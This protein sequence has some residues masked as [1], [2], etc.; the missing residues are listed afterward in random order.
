MQILKQQIKENIIDSSRDYFIKE[1]YEKATL[2]DI[3]DKADISVGN[4]YRYF[5]SK[6]EILLEIMNRFKDNMSKYDFAHNNPLVEASQKEYHEFI[7]V[8]TEIIVENY[9]DFRLTARNKQNEHVLEF[10]SFMMN[11]SVRTIKKAIPESRVDETI[12]RAWTV[13]T[14]EG[15]A[16]LIVDAPKCDKKMAE[17]ISIYFELVLKDIRKRIEVA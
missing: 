17:R 12:A 11:L 9:D 16:E 7:R 5:K 13:A 8:F 10:K 1:G 14:F 6:E 3:A 4:I 2:K 15:L